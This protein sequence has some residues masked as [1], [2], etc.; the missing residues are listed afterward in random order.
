MSD[1]IK[2]FSAKKPLT[3][4]E[5]LELT[6]LILREQQIVGGAIVIYM[7]EFDAPSSTFHTEIENEHVAQGKFLVTTTV[8]P[9]T[10]E[11]KAKI[12]AGKRVE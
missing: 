5:R 2:V 10:E 12:T 4:E 6:S 8:Q 3:E 1:G 9:L 11:L 7:K